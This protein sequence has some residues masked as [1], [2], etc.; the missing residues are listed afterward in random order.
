M[1]LKLPVDVVAVLHQ[2]QSN[3]FEAYVVGGAVRDLFLSKEIPTDWD[4]TTNATPTQIQELFKESFYENDFGTVGI[5]RQHV[6]EQFNLPALTEQGE[7]SNSYNQVIKVEEATKIHES[8]RDKKN[9]AE[10]KTTSKE[11]FEITTFRSDGNY[12]DFRR[13]D[14]VTWGETLEGDLRRRDFTINALAIFI[15]FKEFEYKNYSINLIADSDELLVPEKSVSLIDPFNGLADLHKKYIRTVGKATDRFQED[16]LR[17][18]RAIR[19]AVQLHFSLDEEIFTAIKLHKQLIEHVSFERIRDEVLKML[20][21]KSP[22]RAIE[23]LDETGLL[24]FI[25][26]ELLHTKHVQQGGHHTTDV[27]TH[28]LDALRECPSQDPIVRFATLL[29]DIAKPQT[30]RRTK[31]GITFYNHEVI[32]ARVAKRIAER[33]KLSKL[34]TQR[35]FLLVRHHMFYYQPTITDAAI[36]RFMRKIGLENIN[37]VLDVRI[38]DRLG[39]GSRET[40][41]RLEEMK[42]R[43]LSQLHQPFSVTDLAIDGNDL[44][45]ELGLKPGPILG[46]L[47]K[48]L[49][50]LVL[51]NPDLNTKEDLITEA[52]RFLSSKDEK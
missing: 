16:A 5:D 22:A 3:G 37:D 8:L 7:K 20:G 6:R 2:L 10:I 36:R 43:M 25:L 31:D 21:S 35:M 24:A 42:E 49:F 28:S 30:Y 17:M 14:K 41:W 12:T 38:G 4:F 15:D 44:M 45:K 26:P 13:P 1:D 52:R 47:L 18:L 46:K 34:D 29:H 39:S 48:H 9:V 32:G 40:S 33:F 27:W 50:E 51:E 23:Y 19:F 11:V